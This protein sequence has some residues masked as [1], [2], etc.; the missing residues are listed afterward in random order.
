M[1]TTKPIHYI[2]FVLV[3]VILPW[4]TSLQGINLIASDIDSIMEAS[5]GNDYFAQGFFSIGIHTW[6]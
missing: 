1:K 5:S 3:Q 4:Q 6:R 2:S